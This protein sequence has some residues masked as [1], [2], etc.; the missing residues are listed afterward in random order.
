MELAISAL[1]SIFG[2]GGAAAAAAATTAAATGTAA[3]LTF[4][5]IFATTLSALG[6]LGAAAASAS[7]SRQQAD[8]ADLQA[9]QEQ[10]QAQ[11]RETQMKRSLLNVLGQNDVTFAAAGIDLGQGIA[12]QT[13]NTAKKEAMQQ[14]SIDRSD[15]DFRSALYRARA[16][17]LRRQASAQLG[18]GLIGAL[19]SFADLGSDIGQRGLSLS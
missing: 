2:G 12:Q 3:G 8:Q 6:T 18:G 5:Q 4:G 16:S 1:S 17:G 15:A 9:G 7:A 10:V 11:Q 14:I 13:A 19:G